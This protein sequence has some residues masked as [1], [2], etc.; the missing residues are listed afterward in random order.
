MTASRPRASA[1]ALALLL[2]GGDPARA[3]PPLVVADTAPTHSL[4]SRVMNGVGVPLLLI[5]RSADPATFVLDAT[6]RRT[7]ARASVVFM[8]GRS[9]SP[10]LNASFAKLS[11]AVYFIELSEV[12]GLP[13]PDFFGDAVEGTVPRRIDPY[14]WLNPEVARHWLP[15]IAD[16]LAERDPTN[17]DIYRRNAQ[18]A[19]EE[20]AWL[21]ADVTERMR[22]LRELGYFVP[23]A[24]FTHFERAF[25]LRRLGVA[26]PATLGALQGLE[27]LHARGLVCV[28]LPPEESD[29]PLALRLSQTGLRIGLLDP[30]GKALDLGPELYPTLIARAADSFENCLG[31]DRP[32][33][34][35]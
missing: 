5:P 2:I 34:A 16:A 24:R 6:N 33:V 21:E 14:F 29:S 27:R 4:V 12:P 17:A 13:L 7:L 32:G 11:R 26:S 25:G 22:P 35:D 10:G 1:L 15:V 23:D 20:M 19:A 31:G 3:D 9:L 28:F 18:A 8:V 30:F